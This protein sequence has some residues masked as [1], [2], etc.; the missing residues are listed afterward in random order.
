MLFG[1]VQSKI[2]RKKRT[3]QGSECQAYALYNDLKTIAGNPAP[4]RESL[5]IYDKTL[6]GR[7]KFQ[8]DLQD[9][10]NRAYECR[11]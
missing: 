7:D 2:L 6:R 10:Q 11:S 8:E 5:K 1:K 3:S 9:E 4:I